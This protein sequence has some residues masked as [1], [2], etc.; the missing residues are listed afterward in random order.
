MKKTRAIILLIIFGNFLSLT[1]GAVLIILMSI[2][3]IPSPVW[4][5][6]SAAVFALHIVCAVFSQICFK[7]KFGIS[8]GGYIL[9]SALLS[10]C[11]SAAAVLAGLTWLT[12][13]G[14]SGDSALSIVFGLPL[15]SFMYSALYCIILT[16]ILEKRED[17]VNSK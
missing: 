1:L 12:F 11:I 4:L 6:I 9:Y 17:K 16:V 5:V 7:R 8:E 3:P 15:I 13:T 14:N 10:P 2:T